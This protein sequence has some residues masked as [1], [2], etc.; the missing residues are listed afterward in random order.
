[1]D[2]GSSRG[3]TGANSPSRQDSYEMFESL[4]QEEQLFTEQYANKLCALC[5]LPERSALGQ[6]EIIRFKVPTGVD[7]NALAA[8]ARK[9]S[10]SEAGTS[11]DAGDSD[12]SPIAKRKNRKFT[13]GESNEPVDETDTIGFSEEPELNLLFE[14]SGKFIREENL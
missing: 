8:K 1:M 6:G 9:E 4:C 14:N 7:I 5:N 2:S 11:S 3:S 13:S 10:L 12:K